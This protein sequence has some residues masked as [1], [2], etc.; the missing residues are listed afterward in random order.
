MS[1]WLSISQTILTTFPE[2]RGE[3]TDYTPSVYVHPLPPSRRLSS[4]FL[5]HP[6]STS[7]AV[8]SF[9]LPRF[10][11]LPRRLAALLPLPPPHPPYRFFQEWKPQGCHLTVDNVGLSRNVTAPRGVGHPQ[12]F[13]C[14]FFPMH[15]WSL[16][17]GPLFLLQR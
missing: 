12:G 7:K 6:V 13:N 11:A 1:V 17:P 4:K 9:S 2:E 15:A 10:R 8:A 5:L 14:H 3:L 16:G